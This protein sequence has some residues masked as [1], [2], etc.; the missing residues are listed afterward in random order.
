MSAW[1]TLEM[2]KK[3]VG[4]PLS[5][6]A[7]DDLLRM[8]LENAEAEILEFLNMGGSP[9]PE[10]VDVNA[11][12]QERRQTKIIR[13]KMYQLFAHMWRYRGDDEDGVAPKPALRGSLPPD[14][15]RG[16]LPY[17]RPSLG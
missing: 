13:G 14:I 3:Q 10:P 12:Q 8:Y 5:D 16:L 1:T 17:R 4:V 2:A 7:N 15:E 9:V 6:C 11:S